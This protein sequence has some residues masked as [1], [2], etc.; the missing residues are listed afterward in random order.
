MARGDHIYVHR[1]GYTHHGIDCGNGTVVHYTGEV[2]QKA[3]ASVRRTPIDQFAK[4]S[5]IKVREYGTCDPPDI[6]IQR[7]ESRLN[8][9][10][11]S[12]IFNNCE[13]FA[14]WM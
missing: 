14:T 5:V 3:N 9:T 13:H 1:H 12:L 6:V 8:E 10:K 4:G 2:G 7:A 11:Y